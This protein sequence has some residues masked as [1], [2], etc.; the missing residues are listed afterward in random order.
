MEFVTRWIGVPLYLV[1][2]VL[3]GSVSTAGERE[4]A[5]TKLPEPRGSGM[6]VNQWVIHYIACWN[7]HDA[8]KRRSLIARTWGE[9]GG[10]VDAHRSA[11]GQ[12]AL[13]ATL[14]KSQQTYPRVPLHLLTKIQ[15]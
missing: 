8:L 9:A 1:T 14:T 4:D 15:L 10:Y 2:A 11:K 6:N 5:T 3:M 13:D 12:E 7:E